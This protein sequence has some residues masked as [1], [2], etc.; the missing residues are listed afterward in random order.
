MQGAT[1]F[2]TLDPTSGFFQVPL[3]KESEKLTTFITPFGRFCF[4]RVPMGI[5]LGPEVF[6]TKMKE[7]LE[8]LEGCETIMDDTIVY[9][10]TMEEHD[11][12]LEAVLERIERSGLKL[13]KSE[14][15]LREK[16]VKFF[17]HIINEAGVSPDPDKVKAIRDMPAPTS[18]TELRT[19][20]E[21]LNYMTCHTWL[22]R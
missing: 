22:Q 4:Q 10:R 21:M 12:H 18:M 13:N 2:S 16:Q 1:V 8:G 15:H 17:G 19:V 7:T 6:Q 14:C 20:C 3:Q 9:G 5:S 11:R